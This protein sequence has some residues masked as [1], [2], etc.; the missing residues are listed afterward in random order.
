MNFADYVELEKRADAYGIVDD[1]AL[2]KLLHI[3]V[4]RCRIS[5]TQ[6]EG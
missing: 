5:H 4:Q 1:P 6:A 3:N 2:A